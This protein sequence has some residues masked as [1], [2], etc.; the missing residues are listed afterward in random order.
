MDKWDVK[1]NAVFKTALFFEIS[2]LKLDNLEN[3][4][5]QNGCLF[6]NRNKIF[7]S[8]Y[9]YVCSLI[10]EFFTPFII[11]EINSQRDTLVGSTSQER[12]ASF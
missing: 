4:I 3:F 12:Y 8:C 7:Q 6:N 11:K 9:D 1:N 2:Q 5:F 10:D